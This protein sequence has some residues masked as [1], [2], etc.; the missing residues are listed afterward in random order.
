MP[1]IGDRFQKQK[2]EEPGEISVFLFPDADRTAPKGRF[3]YAVRGAL[4]ALHMGDFKNAHL[5][6]PERRKAFFDI[7]L[8]LA[9]KRLEGIGLVAA[10]I[11]RLYERDRTWA[12]Q[13][14]G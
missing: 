5:I 12:R 14:M 3:R 9:R 7:M 1:I 6:A 8:P 11:D 13:F 2:L 4:S 10:Q